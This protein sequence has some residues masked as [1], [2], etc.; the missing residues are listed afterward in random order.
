MLLG[1][2]QPRLGTAEPTRRKTRGLMVVG[3]G[4]QQDLWNASA[5][6]VRHERHDQSL[7]QACGKARPFR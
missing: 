5:K 6:H 2:R 3:S 4:G 7:P 1:G